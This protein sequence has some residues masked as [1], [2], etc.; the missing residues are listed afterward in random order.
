M[1]MQHRGSAG[2]TLVEIMIVVAIIGILLAVAG[3]AWAKSRT[4]A[5]VN[6]CIANLKQLILQTAASMSFIRKGS[7]NCSSS[8]RKNFRASS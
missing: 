6:T 2:F 5:R 7:C 4:S 1:K 3:P 8:G